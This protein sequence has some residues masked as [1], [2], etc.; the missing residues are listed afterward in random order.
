ME[1]LIEF[2]L[3]LVFEGG[4]EIIKCNKIPKIIR[5]IILSVILLMFISVI[6]LIYLTAFLILKES[7]IGFILLFIIATFVLISAI[8]KFRK[9]YL[10]KINNRNKE[11]IN[12]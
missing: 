2:I 4:L 7:I 10:I 1:Y 3:E 11:N 8:I 9:E 12:N 6:L 5:Y